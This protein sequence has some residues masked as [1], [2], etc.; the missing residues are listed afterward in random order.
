[1]IAVFRALVE[2]LVRRFVTDEGTEMF[3]CGRFHLTCGAEDNRNE[4]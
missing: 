1:V 3:Q 2:G 4:T